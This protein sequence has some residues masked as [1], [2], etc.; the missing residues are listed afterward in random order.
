MTGFGDYPSA[1]TPPSGNYGPPSGG[2]VRLS[3]WWR[4]VGATLIDGIITGLIGTVIA[5]AISNNNGGRYGFD[6]LISLI[7]TVAL[8]GSRG[9]TVGNLAVGTAVVPVDG[10]QLGYGKAFVRW[11]VQTILQVTVI[12]GLLD[13]FWPLWDQRNQTLHDKAVSSLVVIV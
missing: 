8:L 6:A 13:I 9:R 5:L 7:Y 11:L 4:R 12:G 2:G 3:G 10:G 1:P